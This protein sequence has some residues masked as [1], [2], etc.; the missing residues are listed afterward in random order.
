MASVTFHASVGG[1]DSTVSDDT[2]P[3]TGLKRGGHRTRF[4]PALAQ[5]VAVAQFVVT[6]AV[7]AASSASTASA[8][9]AAA[10]GAQANFPPVNDASSNYNVDAEDWNDY[11]RM[12]DTS[13]KT[14]T[15]RPNATHAIPANYQQH[16]RNSGDGDLTF[17]EGS[18]VT[19]NAPYLGSLVVPPSGAVTLKWVATDEYDLVGET[20]EPA[21]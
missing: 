10:T 9:A 4:V 16:F 19:I 1:D 17:V 21:E 6:K 14:V 11:R 5:I 2:S 12:T 3:T 8:A 15:V 13:A 20:L 7:E 18:G